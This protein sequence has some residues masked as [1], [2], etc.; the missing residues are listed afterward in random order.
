MAAERALDVGQLIGAELAVGVGQL[1]E[2]GAGRQLNSA[3]GGAG[4]GWRGGL[5]C[6]EDVAS[7]EAV[8]GVEHVRSW[9]KTR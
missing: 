8:D 5:R 4:I 6:A 1:E 2:K 9:R 3:G 7:D